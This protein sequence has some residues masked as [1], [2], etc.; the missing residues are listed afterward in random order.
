MFDFI[1]RLLF[2][3]VFEIKLK[4][5]VGI[6]INGKVKKAFID[7]CVKV[8]KRE[9]L[10]SITIYGKSSEYGIRLDFSSSTPESS[11]QFFRNAW[12]IYRKH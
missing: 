12:E 10:D 4:N 3:S 11:R 5:G 2:P 7:D 6:L 8:C 9:K 1:R